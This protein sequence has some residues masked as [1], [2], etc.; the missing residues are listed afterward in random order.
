LQ[1]KNE[2]LR[3]GASCPV[4]ERFLTAKDRTRVVLLLGLLLAV[5]AFFLLDLGRY[6]SLQAV[7]AAQG[8]LARWYAESPVT[9]VLAYSLLYIALFALALPVGSVMTLL[10]GALFGF[11]LG[12]VVVSFASTLGATAAFLVS[13][14]VL[15]DSVRQ[16]FGAR[17][18]EVDKGVR[19]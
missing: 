3:H 5:A 9:V 14:Y 2:A 18:A 10:G 8:E 7:Q 19:C 17:L 4:E 6:F 11:W 1:C 15:G 12:V 13:R 16:R